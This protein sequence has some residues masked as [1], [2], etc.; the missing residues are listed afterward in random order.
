[1]RVR[2]KH[3]NPSLSCASIEMRKGESS[4]DHCKENYIRVLFHLK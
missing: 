4:N 3:A 2:E 1:M